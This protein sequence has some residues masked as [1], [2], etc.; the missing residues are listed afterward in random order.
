[1]V[2]QGTVGHLLLCM[3]MDDTG[4]VRRQTLSPNELV[5]HDPGHLTWL[6]TFVRL[7]SRWPVAAT[8]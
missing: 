3:W 4:K 7:A 1:M 8:C 6:R 2:V 5:V